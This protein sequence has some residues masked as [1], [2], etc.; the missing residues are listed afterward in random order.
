MD[1]QFPFATS[2][3]EYILNR[4]EYIARKSNCKSRKVGAVIAVGLKILGE[5][6]NESSCEIC[7]RRMMPDYESGKYL[8]LCLA[9]HAE[10]VA[11]ERAMESF[12][13]RIAR[14]T[15]YITHQPCK[16]CEKALYEA[17]IRKIVYRYPYIDKTEE[18]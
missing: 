8:E 6:C 17:G 10:I 12:L 13:F 14:V 7:R 5:G 9:K 15:A 3:E 1:D 11:L 16:A 4:A 2:F 18:I